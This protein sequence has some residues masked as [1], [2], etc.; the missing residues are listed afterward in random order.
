MVSNMLV[1]E[2]MQ[3]LLCFLSR[4]LSTKIWY[5]MLSR[6]YAFTCVLRLR[7]STKFKPGHSYGHFFPDPQY[8]NVQ[9][10]I[11][12]DFF[13]TYAYDFDFANNVG[14]YRY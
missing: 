6:P 7:T 4:H 2:K 10:I 3:A 13:A 14:F 9:H 11:C 12:C 5:R 8:E 1:K